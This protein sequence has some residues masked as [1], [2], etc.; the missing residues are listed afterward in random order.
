MWLIYGAIAQFIVASIIVLLLKLRLDDMLLDLAARQ[1]EFW[2]K[3]SGRES[4]NR[5]LVVVSYKTLKPVYCERLC[6]SWREGWGDN[7][8]PIFK[9]EPK[10]LGGIIIQAGDHKIDCSLQDRLQQAFGKR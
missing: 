5:E 7:L 6:K 9:L 3:T 10:L 2:L 1:F 4:K 8:Q